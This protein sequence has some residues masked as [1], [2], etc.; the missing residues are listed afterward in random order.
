MVNFPTSLDT[1]TNPQASD[2]MDTAGVE[3]DI[4]HANLNDIVEALEA[5]VGIDNSNDTGSID[6]RLRAVEAALGSETDPWSDE[7]NGDELNIS[8]WA[9]L[10]QGVAEVSQ[11]DGCLLITQ[12][13]H[14]STDDVKMVVQTAPTGTWKVRAKLAMA[15]DLEESAYPGVYLG[16]RESSTG[17]IEMIGINWRSGVNNLIHFRYN[18]FFSYASTGWSNSRFPFGIYYFEVEKTETDLIWR[19]SIEGQFF[20]QVLSKPIT[21][22]FTSGPDQIG[23]C[24]NC[25]N[26]PYEMVAV[27]DWIRRI[28]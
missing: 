11:S 25:F 14:G 28:S 2:A 7:F 15:F 22:F 24:A 6:Y 13:A 26:T 3:H 9:I 5:K 16:L 23:L 1:L 20:R 10:N 21:T 8:K 12:P 18:S 4:Q 19:L 27:C 17:K